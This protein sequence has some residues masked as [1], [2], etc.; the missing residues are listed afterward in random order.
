MKK[1]IYIIGNGGHAKVIEG[2]LRHIQPGRS[3]TK[4]ISDEDLCS[5]KFILERDFLELDNIDC[6]IY[7]GVGPRPFGN[8]SNVEIIKKY[9]QNAFVFQNLISTKSL[10]SPNIEVNTGIQI[11]CGSIVSE[12]VSIGK[13]S[14]LN[15][16]VIIEHDCII[17]DFCHIS[18]GAIVCGGA[19][20]GNQTFIGAGAVILPGVKIGANVTISANIKVQNDVSEGQVVYGY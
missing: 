19:S 20:I 8:K 12:D 15:H 5:K 17:G 1:S 11:F 18:P 6:D 9:T 2:M 16:G 7:N 3:V 10:I 4:V 14:V 13:H